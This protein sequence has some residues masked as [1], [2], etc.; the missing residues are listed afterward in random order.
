MHWYSL[1]YFGATESEVKFSLLF[2]SSIEPSQP[3]NNITVNAINASSVV[4][5]WLP[6][7]Q[8]HQNGIIQSYTIRIVG[9]HTDDDFILGTNS[10]RIS[11]NSLHP[12]YSYKFTVAAVT[13][14]RGPFSM[15][16]TIAMP[17]LG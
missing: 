3:P 16:I 15:P 4:V 1:N 9:V 11:V 12:F 8:E 2:Q 10:T 13:I 14:S 5:L 17:S 6:P 7:S